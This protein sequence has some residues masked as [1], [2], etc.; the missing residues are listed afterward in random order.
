MM[1]L[2]NT[3]TLDPANVLVYNLTLL[4]VKAKKGSYKDHLLVCY[5]TPSHDG[6]SVLVHNDNKHRLVMN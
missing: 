3:W 4:R 5:D 6:F 1:K 2:L